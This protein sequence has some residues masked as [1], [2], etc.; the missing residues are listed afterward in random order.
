MDDILK[1]K[2]NIVDNYPKEGIRFLDLT[3]ILHDNVSFNSIITTLANHIEDA[4]FIIAPEARGFIWGAALSYVTGLPLIL[5]RK[6]GKIPPTLVGAT[7]TYKTEYSTDTLEVED[8]KIGNDRKVIF[9]DDIY[10]TGGTY[11]ACKDLVKQL[12]GE[13]FKGLVICDLELVINPEID[14][15]YKGDDLLR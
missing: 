8:I 3:P 2:Y 7:V 13:V 5:A 1:V 14:S 11:N 9:V 10:A 6:K 12:G 15:I 4:E